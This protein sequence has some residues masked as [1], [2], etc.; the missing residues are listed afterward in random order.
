M[1]GVTLSAPLQRVSARRWI[2]HIC[3]LHRLLN[4]MIQYARY[5]LDTE[6]GANCRAYLGRRRAE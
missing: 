5:E 4:E 3:R 6:A 2:L 1:P